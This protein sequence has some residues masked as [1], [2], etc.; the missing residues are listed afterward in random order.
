MENLTPALAQEKMKRILA[1][2][3]KIVFTWQGSNNTNE[4]HYYSIKTDS[5]IIEFSN[6]DGGIYH[7][8]TLWRDLSEDFLSK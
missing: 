1:A 2:K 6:R 4:L 3:E 7:Y 5:F 8:H